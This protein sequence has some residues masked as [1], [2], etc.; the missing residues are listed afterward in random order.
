[1]TH[2]GKTV[3]PECHHDELANFASPT[4]PIGGSRLSTTL[5]SRV[6]GFWVAIWMR[7]PNPLLTQQAT[8]SV[9]PRPRRTLPPVADS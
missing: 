9:I 1:M 4:Q 5:P 3:D 8:S 6:R 2:L 7:K